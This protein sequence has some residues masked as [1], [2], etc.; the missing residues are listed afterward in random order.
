M[1]RKKSQIPVIKSIII[2]LTVVIII[3]TFL[4]ILLSSSEIQIDNKKIN[5]Q[6]TMNKILNSGCFSKEYATIEEENFNEERLNECFKGID[7]SILFRLKLTNNMIYAGEENTFN[8]KKLLCGT[9]RNILCTKLI[10]PITY[11]SNDQ[12]TSIES[13]TVEIITS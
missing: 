4:I 9:N 12:K 8:Q 7:N 3:T 13:L 2:L 10:Y 1:F 11:I 6:L 5:T